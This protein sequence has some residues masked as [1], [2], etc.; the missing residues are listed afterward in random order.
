MT[1]MADVQ[2]QRIGIQTR[3]T[4]WSLPSRNSI[5]KI[6]SLNDMLELA[7]ELAANRTN[8]LDNAK[9]NFMEVLFMCGWTLEDADIYC[10]QGG[11]TML[12][13]RTYDN[14]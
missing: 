6:K 7:D 12:V 5:G 14:L 3:D 2:A 10:E 11:L 9:S 13:T 8:V 1:D 4:Q